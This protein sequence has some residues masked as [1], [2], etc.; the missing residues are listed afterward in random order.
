MGNGAGPID[1]VVF[2]LDGTLVHTLPD[3]HEALDAVLAEAGRRRLDIAET[4]AGIGGGARALVAEALHAGG[5]ACSE[6]EIDAFHA[7]FAAAYAA[8]PTLRSRPFDGVVRCLEDFA[9]RGVRMA[10]CT[11]KPFDLTRSVLAGVDLARFF[12]AVVAG[13]SLPVR[14]PDPAP[15]LE[16]VARCGGR[17]AGALM[18]GDGAADAG[19][20]RA[21]NLPFI[22]VDYGYGRIPA[23]DLGADLVIDGFDALAAGIERIAGGGR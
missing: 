19:A 4:R 5:R 14:K 7:R 3:I 1:T 23:A 2:D 13:D 11:N 18:V 12:G 9:S 20:A 22:A 10:V 8:R 6:E 15:L 21:A 16:A 17:R